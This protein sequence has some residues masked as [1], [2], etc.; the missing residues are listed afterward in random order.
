MSAA[1]NASFFYW[2]RALVPNYL[3]SI[4]EVPTDAHRI[5]YFFAALRDCLPQLRQAVHLVRLLK[6]KKQ[7]NKLIKEAGQEGE[8]ADLEE[9]C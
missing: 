1:C 4:Y 2:H 5:H 7:L 9:N 3:K 8:E 6:K